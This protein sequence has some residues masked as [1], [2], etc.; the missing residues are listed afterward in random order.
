MAGKLNQSSAKIA[1]LYFK[2][3]KRPRKSKEDKGKPMPVTVERL[4]DEPILIATFSGEVHV[5]DMVEMF[6][7]SADLMGDDDT[8]F[9]RITDA[10]DATSNF[11]EMFASI[12]EA[13][14]GQPGSTTDAR[15]KASFVGTSTWIS[16]ARNALM[17]P[18]FGGLK[19][20]AFETVDD[21]LE[22]IRMQIA[23]GE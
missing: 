7:L 9:Y 5:D 19:L 4:E 16:F 20:A 14:T 15:I 2:L 1:L 21:A 3:S 11:M 22:N 17:N 18:K 13:S 10:R 23:V 8:Q 12:K 6:K